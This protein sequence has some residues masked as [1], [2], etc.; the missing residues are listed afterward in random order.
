MGISSALLTI[1]VI[2]KVCSLR[3]SVILNKLTNVQTIFNI[4]DFLKPLH[5]ELIKIVKCAVRYTHRPT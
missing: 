4:T 2:S 3:K 1:L 5:Q